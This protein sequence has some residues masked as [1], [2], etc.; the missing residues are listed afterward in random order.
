[1]DILTELAAAKAEGRAK[2]IER[3]HFFPL[4][5]IK[6]NAAFAAD[7]GGAAAQPA[8]LA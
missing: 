1:M 6:T 4:G 5:G 8:N 3:I 7:H 2:N